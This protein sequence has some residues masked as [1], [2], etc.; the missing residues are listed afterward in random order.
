MLRSAL[1]IDKQVHGENHPATLNAAVNLAK[2]GKRS[3]VLASSASWNVQTPDPS[4]ELAPYTAERLREVTSKGFSPQP[5]LLAPLRVLRVEKAAAG[6][7]NVIAQWK[8]AEDLPP[9]GPMR[10]LLAGK[11][12]GDETANT[13]TPRGAVGSELVVHTAQPPVLCTGFQGSVASSAS[14]L[15][16][17]ADGSNGA[18]GCLAG[19]PLLTANDESTR[20]S[21]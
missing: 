3:T 13:G 17:L 12:E 19:A 14:H 9:Q 8:A 6:G 1:A 10:K 16:D 2:A 11:A 7:F 21:E 4:S 18:K 5:A 15:F 20:V